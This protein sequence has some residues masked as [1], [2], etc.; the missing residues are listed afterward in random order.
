[1]ALHYLPA[2]FERIEPD[3][4]TTLYRDPSPWVARVTHLGE[5]IL[6]TPRHLER[7]PPSLAF[8]GPC[9]RVPPYFEWAVAEGFA[10]YDV[11]EADGSIGRWLMRRDRA[12]EPADEVAGIEAEGDVEIIDIEE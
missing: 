9:M 11:A 3:Y 6:A 7:E 1:M 8:E 10:L 12:L 2:P 4:L 5:V